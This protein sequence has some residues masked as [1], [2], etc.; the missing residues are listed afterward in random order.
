MWI[1]HETDPDAPP[2]RAFGFVCR[3]V[4]TGLVHV[5]MPESRD[6]AALADCAVNTLQEFGLKWQKQ[7]EGR[8][9]AIQVEDR[10]LK[11]ALEA[12]RADLDADVVLV[13]SLPELT[14]V[15][16]DLQEGASGDT[17]PN[18]LD[19]PAITVQMVRAF[20][21]VAAEFH[22]AA[23]WRLFDNADLI[24]VEHGG[25][26]RSVSRVSVMGAG[27]EE[28]GL[29]FYETQAQFERLMDGRVP[30]RAFGVTFEPCDGL[31]FGDVDLWEDEHLPVDGDEGYPLA[32]EFRARGVMRR[33][34]SDELAAIEGLL[35]AIATVTEEEL[36][37][38]TWNTSVSTSRG[39]LQL[40]L[41]LP[42]V[43]E[44]LD[45]TT[46]GPSSLGDRDRIQRQMAALLSS[47][48]FGS[49][50]DANAAL[51]Q[52]LISGQFDKNT[53]NEVLSPTDEA[54]EWEVVRWSGTGGRGQRW[55]GG[56]SHWIR[57][58][59]MRGRR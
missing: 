50:E 15:L 44:A 34:T 36:D 12:R 11:D 25:V 29:A 40:T 45:P 55:R 14:A 16:R 31:P 43:V 6:A 26:P 33:P 7:L 21:E 30:E 51:Q 39:P 41:T 4:R 22:R 17:R 13:P 8:P 19:D 27:G 10:V 18:L 28:F 52:A 58:V 49:I 46:V 53:E 35:R 32:A 3:S 56:R 5:G 37:R 23:P 48:E 47:R 1:D 2:T 38:G 20:A 54:R 59:P 42:E 57:T 9:A 24:I